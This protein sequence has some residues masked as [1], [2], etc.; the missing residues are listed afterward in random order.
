MVEFLFLDINTGFSIALG[1]VLAIAFLE[2][3]GLVIG[4]SLMNLLDQL[5]PIDLDVDA[6]IELPSGGLTPILAWLFLNRL[7]LL[8][9][10]VLYLT[11]FGVIG[12]TI[13]YIALT[14]ADYVISG[15]LAYS[16]SL[17]VAA[18]ATH[19]IGGPLSRLLPKNESSAMSNDSFNGLIAQIT[20]GRARFDSPA[21]AVL[22]DKFKQKHYVLLAPED[23]AETFKQGEQVVLVEK[24][25]THWIGVRFTQ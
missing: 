19:L 15:W 16:A 22:T 3:I 8:V 21:E 20:I 5:S 10:L 2:G 11:C 7:P 9:W 24:T 1:L 23:E 6:D 14:K 18:Y 17:L 4:L 13:N 25:E 12:L